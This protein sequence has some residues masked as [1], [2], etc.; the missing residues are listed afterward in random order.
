[1]H[2][3][4]V[5]IQI[6]CIVADAVQSLFKKKSLKQDHEESASKTRAKP[7]QDT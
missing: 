6:Q 4:Y 2:T 3:Y 5:L 1:M 7:H